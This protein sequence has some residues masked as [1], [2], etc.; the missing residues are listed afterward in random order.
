MLGCFEHQKSEQ[1]KTFEE[2]Y[3]IEK[4]SERVKRYDNV[5]S[6]GAQ[7]CSAHFTGVSL[8][9]IGIHLRYLVESCGEGFFDRLI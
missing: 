5:F 2:I 9:S 3:G 7:N 8:G 1:S 4:K 6:A